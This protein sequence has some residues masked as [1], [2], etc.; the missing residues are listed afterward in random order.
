MVKDLHHGDE[1]NASFY[2]GLLVSAY[3]VAEALTAM[4]WGA[5]SDKYGRKPVVL[6]ALCGVCLSSLIFGLSKRY[7]VALLA[8]FVGGALN[9]NVAVMQTMVAELVKNPAHEPKAYAV[10]PFVWA[11]GSIIG[12]AMGGFL[13]QPAKFYPTIFSEEGLFGQ[14][15]Y[16]LPNLVAMAII[17]I[18]VIQGIFL[19][20]E[21]NPRL[22]QT[23]QAAMVPKHTTE[24]DETS[25]LLRMRSSSRSLISHSRSVSRRPQQPVFLEE[26]LP[27][28]VDQS[29]DLRRSSFGTMHSIR[30]SHDFGERPR[31]PPLPTIKSETR[32]A[33]PPTFNFTII[34]LTVS[35]VLT[36][37]HQMAS[38]T[39]L[40]IY[41]VDTPSADQLD[42]VGGLDFTL[43]DVG[44]YLAVNGI[45]VV[46]IQGV[47]FPKFVERVGVWLSFV[48]TIL[49][50]PLSYVIVP[51]LSLLLGAQPDWLLPL[52]IYATLFTQ[53]LCAVISGPCI[54]ILLKN[55]IRKDGVLGKVNG[56]VMSLCCAARTFGPPL[57]GL[58]YSEG[59]SAAAWGSC[60]LVALVGTVQLWWVPREERGKEVH[61]EVESAF[62]TVD[63]HQGEDCAVVDD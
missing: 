48:V 14:Y 10:Q 8:R 7:W 44:M 16:L 31:R 13:A 4:M 63:Y 11:L 51:F 49:L 23:S 30:V 34:M 58:I 9:G 42:L 29:F 37:Y 26:G 57:V 32:P 15:P 54:L 39:V 47:I 38:A 28:L 33:E 17:I 18:A 35:L 43:H 60:A 2:A 50:Y 53:N 41:L 55:A 5:I 62:K 6:F 59:G 3:A 45:M 24:S 36:A 40:P 52:G 25:P 61:V 19:L 56:M 20:E 21:T 1:H 12:S 46:F 22:V 27:T